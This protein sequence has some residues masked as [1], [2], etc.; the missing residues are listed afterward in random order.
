MEHAMRQAQITRPRNI[1]EIAKLAVLSALLCCSAAMAGDLELRIVDTS[2]VCVKIDKVTRRETDKVSHRR[3]SKK[4]NTMT[5][6]GPMKCTLT[7]SSAESRNVRVLHK[8]QFKQPRL[9]VYLTGDFDKSTPVG[10][11][12]AYYPE[13]TPF[14]L[15][16]HESQDFEPV[17]GMRVS[18]NPDDPMQDARLQKIRTDSQFGIKYTMENGATVFSNQIN[19]KDIK[20]CPASKQK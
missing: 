12:L 9:D 14:S 20:T 6:A 8:Q 11:W 16:P 10:D 5:V 2:G 18:M 15:R 17:I 19:L 7:N 1:H 4:F 3:V 13:W